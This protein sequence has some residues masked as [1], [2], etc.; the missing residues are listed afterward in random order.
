MIRPV[1]IVLVVFS[2]PALSDS[3]NVL[4]NLAPHFEPASDRQYLARG[5]DFILAVTPGG[6]SVGNIQIEFVHARGDAK[7]EGD[8]LQSGTSN[9]LVGNDPSQWRTN[10]RHY[11]RVSVRGVYPGIDLAL[12]FK[13]GAFEYD[14]IVAPGAEPARIRMKFKGDAKLR[15]DPSGDIVFGPLTHRRPILLQAGKSIGGHYLRR[16]N[17]VAFSLPE[18]DRRKELII[19]PTLIYSTYLWSCSG[20]RHAARY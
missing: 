20:G 15:L 19:D 5:R 8:C 3:S 1:A 16:G 13:D 4:S 2:L 6:I 18:Y 9:Y 12:Y 11:S 17:E 10:V 14:W 7:L